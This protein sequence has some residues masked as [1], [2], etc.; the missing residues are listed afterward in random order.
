LEA[1]DDASTATPADSSPLC[2]EEMAS[3]GPSQ[4]VYAAQEMRDALAELSQVLAAHSVEHALVTDL[5]REA[6][7][8]IEREALAGGQPNG[9][10][11]GRDVALLWG[12][13]LHYVA[14][15]ESSADLRLSLSA[16]FQ[17]ALLRSV[18]DIDLVI[19]PYWWWPAH[20]TQQEKG[21]AL[22]RLL[23][24]KSE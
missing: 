20:A 21:G 18:R 19:I 17:V 7:I 23:T 3:E 9:R 22:L 8:L 12:S 14:F 13:S 11:L 10:P 5:G 2:S 24:E 6:H 15:D 16:Q 4:G 1:S